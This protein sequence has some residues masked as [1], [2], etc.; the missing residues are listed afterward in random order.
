M[1]YS[2]EEAGMKRRPLWWILVPVVVI[3]LVGAGAIGLSFRERKG[4]NVG[5][6]QIALAGYDPVSYFPEGGG[7]P[8]SGDARFTASRQG[9][10]YH[11]SSEANRERFLATP[12]RYEPA[13]G[14]WCAYAVAHGYKFEVDP[15]SYLV[16]DGRLLLFYRGL[17]GD[18]RA[19]F[20]KEGVA[21]GIRQ[22][23][24]NWPKLAQE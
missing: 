3:A 12:E 16:E 17:L 8:R 20:E 19:E 5:A 11:F 1:H 7:R 2:K 23:D 10:R 24:A 6:D 21:S 4:D 9:R 14:G 15:E 18:A 13:F 22:A